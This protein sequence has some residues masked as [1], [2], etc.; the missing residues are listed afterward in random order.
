MVMSRYFLARWANIRKGK[1]CAIID[2]SSCT[3]LGQPTPG[4]VEYAACKSLNGWF[5]KGI[6]VEYN[7]KQN[8]DLVDLDVYTVYPASVKT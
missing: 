4:I 6:N 3:A 5:S 2:Y 8:K 7:A 1:K